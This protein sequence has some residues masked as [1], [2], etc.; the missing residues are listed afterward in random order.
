MR[1]SYLFPFAIAI[2]IVAWIFSGMMVQSGPADNRQSGVA[3]NRKSGSVDNTLA[4]FYNSRIN[5]KMD[6]AK[7]IDPLT[8]STDNLVKCETETA[9]KRADFYD[10]HRQKLVEEMLKDPNIGTR[11]YKVDDF[12]VTSFL[13]AHRGANECK[14]S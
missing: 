4:N 7:R 12:L 13:K 14:L 11:D 6:V 2:W 9:L 10:K 5:E 3:D 1:L 8:K